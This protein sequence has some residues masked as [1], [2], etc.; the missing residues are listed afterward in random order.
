MINTNAT[1]AGSLRQAITDA[2][3]AGGADTISFAPGVTGTI[4]PSPTVP[5]ITGPTTIRDRARRW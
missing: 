1:G 5:N 2:N 3:S 4:T